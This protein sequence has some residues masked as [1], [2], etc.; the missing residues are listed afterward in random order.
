MRPPCIHLDKKLSDRPRTNNLLPHND[1][2]PFFFVCVYAL[3][4]LMQLGQLG[5]LAAAIAVFD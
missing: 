1:L 3:Y 4:A 5:G 2:R